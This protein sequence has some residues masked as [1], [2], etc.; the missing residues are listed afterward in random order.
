MDTY[1]ENKANNLQKKSS[2]RQDG[3]Y[4]IFHITNKNKE[5]SDD[6]NNLSTKNEQLVNKENHIK[7][8]YQKRSLKTSSRNGSERWKRKSTKNKRLLFLSKASC[9]STSNDAINSSISDQLMNN[10]FQSIIPNDAGSKQFLTI[11]IEDD[12]QNNIGD[13]SQTDTL[14]EAID[15]TI[16]HDDATLNNLLARANVL[17]VT[18]KQ[19]DFNRVRPISQTRFNQRRKR[20]L[21]AFISVLIA[22]IIFLIIIVFVVVMTLKHKAHMNRISKPSSIYSSYR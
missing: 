5:E 20:C 21:V 11:D 14:I 4:R 7:P 3:S 12:K 19:Q 9:E 6:E 17:E 18:V 16:A 1:S 15:E 10:S 8:R 2:F 13:S 22:F